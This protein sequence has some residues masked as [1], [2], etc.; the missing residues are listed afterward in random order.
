MIWNKI[1]KIWYWIKSYWYLPFILV[2]LIFSVIFLRGSSF[3]TWCCNKWAGSTERY[4]VQREIIE[5]EEIRA[6]KEKEKATED[7]QATVQELTENYQ[8]AEKELKTK[9]K[10]EIQER[11]KEYDGDYKKLAEDM[12]NKYGFRYV[13]TEE[14]Q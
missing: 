7:Y 2:G 3:F 11:V 6:Q 9:Q 8:I 4:D 14:H 5:Q 10:K 1:K 12:A 13:N